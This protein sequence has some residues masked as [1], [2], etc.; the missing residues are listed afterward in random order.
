MHHY[1]NSDLFS[2]IFRQFDESLKRFFLIYAAIKMQ[3]WPNMVLLL[4][5]LNLFVNQIVKITDD[6]KIEYF[7]QH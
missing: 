4:Y 7:W 5:R 2:F 1:Q 3:S 6:F